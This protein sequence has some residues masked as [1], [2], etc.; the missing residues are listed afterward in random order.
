MFA[1]NCCSP[2]GLGGHCRLR[3]DW[4]TGDTVAAAPCSACRVNS[5]A[6]INV[7]AQW[8]SDHLLV[9]TLLLAASAFAA[10]GMARYVRQSGVA[11]AREHSES[12]S[13]TSARQTRLWVHTWRI[14]L[15]LLAATLAITWAVSPWIT[16]VL[17]ELL[18]GRSGLLSMLDLPYAVRVLIGFLLLDLSAYALHWAAH[19][20]GWLWRLHQVHHSDTAMNA[21]THFR[22]HPLVL[23]VALAVQLPVLWVLGIPAVS[24]VLF[25][26]L[27]TTVQL[28][29]H[30][31]TSAP[32]WVERTLGWCLVTP[33]FHWRHHHPDRA[34]HDHNYGAVFSWWDRLFRTHGPAAQ[35]D[36]ATPSPTGLA[37]YSA[38]DALSF[39]AC[40]MA[41]F[42]SAVPA[43]DG[44]QI[45]PALV[46]R[47]ARRNSKVNATQYRKT[48]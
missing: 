42:V 11:D 15:L 16:P 29:H 44:A 47:A 40:V 26:A 10:E 35:I 27:S 3:H 43:Q 12:R 7:W 17:S 34:V 22:Q 4:P 33:R 20:F 9:L 37:R 23:L 14:N 8:L 39:F 45:G 38:K 46:N 2:R 19:R 24:W 25:A 31:N 30:S 18:R 21:S 5:L 13:R 1:Q 28:W 36:S 48:L 41:P 32:A 6:T